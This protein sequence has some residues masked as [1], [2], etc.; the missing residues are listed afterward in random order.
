MKKQAIY[1]SKEGTY[2]ELVIETA[3]LQDS[4][5]LKERT[6][7][8]DFYGCSID[9]K[10]SLIKTFTLQNYSEYSLSSEEEFKKYFQQ[11]LEVLQ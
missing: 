6:V 9:F 2:K 3:A 5:T 1:L 10:D 7:I 11:A 4:L 8:N